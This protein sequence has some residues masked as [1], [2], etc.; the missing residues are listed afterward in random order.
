LGTEGF[1]SISFELTVSWQDSGVAEQK[2]AVVGVAG[3]AQHH[4]RVP[5]GRDV[6][7]WPGDGSVQSGKLGGA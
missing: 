3:D 4:L 2:G 7:T 6:R 1:W 5:T